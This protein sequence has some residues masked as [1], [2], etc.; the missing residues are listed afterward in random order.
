[1]SDWAHRFVTSWYAESLSI[2]PT[3]GSSGG[4]PWRDRQTET[5][6]NISKARMRFLPL[7]KARSSED[8]LGFDKQ[9][10]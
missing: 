8:A 10:P 9:V 7:A 6:E 5:T 3:T 4:V 1:M 2:Q